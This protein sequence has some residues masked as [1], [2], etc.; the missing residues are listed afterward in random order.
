[1]P[2]GP[3]Q[4]IEVNPGQQALEIQLPMTQT[5][6]IGG[7]ITDQF[8]NPLGRADVQAVRTIYQ[9]GRRVFA[10]VK[11]GTTDDRGEYRLF[12][13]PPGRYYVNVLAAGFRQFVVNAEAPS[14]PM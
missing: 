9:D 5:G 14:A 12:W 8:G 6:V 7:R 4:S 1:M 3:A 2:N 13:L 11:S 10:A